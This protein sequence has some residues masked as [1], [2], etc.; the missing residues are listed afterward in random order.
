VAGLAALVWVAGTA[1]LGGAGIASAQ[2]APGVA[3]TG[4]T[5]AVAATTGSTVAVAATTGSTVALA[6]TVTTTTVVP[7]PTTTS[8]TRAAA[9]PSTTS[10]SSTVPKP[11]WAARVPGPPAPAAVTAAS[12]AEV[13][14]ANALEAEIASQS[15][16][17]DKVAADYDKAE[18][19]V[20]ATQAALDQVRGRLATAQAQADAA[21]SDVAQAGQAVRNVAVAAYVNVGPGTPRGAAALVGAYEHGLARADVDN[22]VGTALARVQQ[23]SQAEQR[24]RAAA[25]QVAAEEQ[26]AGDANRAAQAAADRAQA[27]AKAATA[28][29]AQLLATVT[30]VSDNL[31]PLVAAAR[32]ATAQAAFDR[33]QTAGGLDFK[34]PAALAAPPTQAAAAAQLAGAQVG[35]PYVWGAAGP[36]SF[37]CSGLVQWIWAKLGVALPRVAADQ[38]AWATPVPISE[39]APGDLVFFGS[40]A[41]HVGMYIGGGLMVDAPYTGALVSVSSIW[42]NDLAGFGRVHSR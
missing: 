35:K 8:T 41:H 27:A 18:E 37:D 4:S 33:F 13:A 16:V 1:G 42:W 40:P 17:L 38:Q 24:L 30:Q 5:V 7:A 32:A 20:T 2:P 31:A 39:L 3:P 29:Q 9:V 12:P 28:Q 25:R 6:A 22:A 21:Q 10:T 34:A 11:A 19:T 36:D 26:R 14:V 15:Q 23:L